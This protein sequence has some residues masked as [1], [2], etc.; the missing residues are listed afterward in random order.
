MVQG[1]KSNVLREEKKGGGGDWS[2]PGSVKK[3]INA[4]TQMTSSCYPFYSEV[5]PQGDSKSI[6][7]H[8]GDWC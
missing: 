7:M 4:D 8:N 3:G 2:H 6:Q 5:C 1:I